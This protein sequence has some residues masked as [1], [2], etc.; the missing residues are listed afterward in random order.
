MYRFKKNVS[1]DDWRRQGQ[2]NYLKDV[3]LIFKK[4]PLVDSH[5]DHDHCEFCGTKFSNQKGD[6]VEGYTTEEE[7]HWICKQCYNDFKIDF[8]WKN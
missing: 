4:Y 1:K 6:T 7:Y 2:E 3:E 5:N 8:N